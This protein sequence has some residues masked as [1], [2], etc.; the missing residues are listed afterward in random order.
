MFFI[1]SVLLVS[2]L[3]YFPKWKLEQFVCGVWILNIYFI[4][5]PRRG[6]KFLRRSSDN[7]S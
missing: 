2:P 1:L 5:G 4:S 3:R 7:R 6:L